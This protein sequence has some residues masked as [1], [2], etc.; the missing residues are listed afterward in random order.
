MALTSKYF[1]S[2]PLS[3]IEMHTLT[4]Q[5]YTRH[6]FNTAEEAVLKAFDFALFDLN[7]FTVSE[8][9]H[10]YLESCR[11]I[12][13]ADRFDLIC[14]NAEKFLDFYICSPILSGR[15]QPVLA[16]VACRAF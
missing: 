4:N 10:L 1:E 9:L 6:Q 2:N 13:P 12:L 15:F 3:I 14:S 8:L 16:A 5:A 11:P 7:R